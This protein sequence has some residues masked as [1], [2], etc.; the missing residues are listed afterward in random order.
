VYTTK[1]ALAHIFASGFSMML[2]FPWC[3]VFSEQTFEQ[4][5]QYRNDGKQ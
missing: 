5:Q 2:D 4:P 3:G 1:F